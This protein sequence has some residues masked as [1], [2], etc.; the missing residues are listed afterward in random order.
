[1]II[2]TLGADDLSLE[3]KI[4][5]RL[6][7][8]ARHL[9]THAVFIRMRTFREGGFST[10]N[11]TTPGWSRSAMVMHC[12]AAFSIGEIRDLPGSVPGEMIGWSPRARHQGLRFDV[13]DKI[14]APRRSGRTACLVAVTRIRGAA[15][16]ESPG[17]HCCDVG[18]RNNK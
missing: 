2:A 11:V 15:T 12:D 17:L 18:A 1:M 3:G 13:L 6:D 7:H 5:T 16:G 9:G 10:A 4:A 8:P 14:C